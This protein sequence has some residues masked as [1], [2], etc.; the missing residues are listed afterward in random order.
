MHFMIEY[1]RQIICDVL[2][3][4]EVV[5]FMEACKNFSKKYPIILVVLTLIFDYALLKLAALL[6]SS[7]LKFGIYECTM[8]I[9]IFI[10]TFLF[11]G[12]EKVSFSAKG[13]RYSFRSVRGYLI[14]MVILCVFTILGGILLSVT[15]QGGFHY[16]LIGF[17][18]ILIVALFVGIAEEF[19]FRGLIFGGLLQKLGNTKQ[20]I[21]LAAFLSGFL[22]G[23][24]HVFDSIVGGQVTDAGSVITAIL[25]TAQAGVFGIVLAFIYY[26]TRNI[27]AVAALHSL[28]DFFLLFSGTFVG[29]E[30]V[31]YVTTTNAKGASIAYIV[32]ILIVIPSIVRGIRNITPE[33]A[34]PFDEDFLPRTV[35]FEKKAKKNKKVK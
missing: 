28:N 15:Q 16:D 23:V 26:K 14:F 22:F 25:K 1:K 33:E 11:M 35:V 18:N 17:I 10:V 31:S 13:F 20:N 9:V 24:M 5:T 2:K 21:I 3:K 32:F 12:K 27:F 7:P 4:Y 30:R 34:I 19:V 29:G 8:A 6:P